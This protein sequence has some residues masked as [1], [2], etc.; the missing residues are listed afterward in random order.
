MRNNWIE[1]LESREGYFL[2]AVQ[3]YHQLSQK[4]GSH[5]EL[6]SSALSHCSLWL[7]EASL[8]QAAKLFRLSS[9]QWSRISEVLI[10]LDEPALQEA[11]LLI[12]LKKWN[13]EHSMRLLSQ[14]VESKTPLDI[15]FRKE[16]LEQTLLRIIELESSALE[17]ILQSE[18]TLSMS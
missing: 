9:Q 11:F 5:R 1:I 15:S 17:S 10:S 12:R 3:L 14:F 6:M 4:N 18:Q 8:M 2:L 13:H 7:S 16:V